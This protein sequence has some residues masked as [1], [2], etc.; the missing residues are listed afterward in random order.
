MLGH[1]FLP[2]LC[3]ATCRSPRLLQDKQDSRPLRPRGRTR[4]RWPIGRELAVAAADRTVR[5]CRAVCEQR[6]QGV[7]TWGTGSRR[8]LLVGGGGTSSETAGGAGAASQQCR[9]SRLGKRRRHLLRYTLFRAVGP[10]L[11]IHAGTTHTGRTT[12]AVSTRRR[13]L[14]V[15]PLSPTAAHVELLWCGL[16]AGVPRPWRGE[17]LAQR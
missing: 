1:R 16:R 5:S 12:P 6:P 8:P 14:P 3:V 9:C 13:P 4:Q 2:L 15:W 10:I 11:V 17:G 7:E